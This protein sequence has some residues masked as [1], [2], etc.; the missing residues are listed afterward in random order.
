MELGFLEPLVARWSRSRTGIAGPKVCDYY[1]Q[2]HPGHRIKGQSVPGKLLPAQRGKDQDHVQ[3]VFEV[4]YVAGA[5][6]LISSALIKKIGLIP[7]E[8]FLFFEE[9]EWCLKARRAGQKVVCVCESLIYHKGSKSIEKVSGIQEDHMT[10][11]RSSLR[12]GTPPGP[13]G[14]GVYLHRWYRMALSLPRAG[15]K[16]G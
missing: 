10:R 2:H 9:T 7:E 6:L 14:R 8:Y 1:D 3:G 16:A 11:T 5:C 15:S 4:D 12:R 13:N